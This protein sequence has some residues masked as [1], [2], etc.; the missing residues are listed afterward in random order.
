MDTAS[1]A[2][3]A[4]KASAFLEACTE[5]LTLLKAAEQRIGKVQATLTEGSSKVETMRVA[6]KEVVQF[7]AALNQ[8]AVNH[9]HASIGT[10]RLH[11]CIVP[12]SETMQISGCRV[13]LTKFSHAV[14]DGSLIEG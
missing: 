6:A 2:E 13:F 5:T 10:P 4:Q 14:V 7:I 3:Q 11:A 1:L 9:R 12:V 8:N